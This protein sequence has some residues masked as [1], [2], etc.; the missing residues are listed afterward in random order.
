MRVKVLLLAVFAFVA[1]NVNGQELKFGAKAGLNVSNFTGSDANTKSKMGFHFGAFAQYGFSEALYLQPELL[2]S[3]EG[4]KDKDND[5]K[6][7]SV[8]YLNVPVM[9]GYKIGSISIEAGPQIGFLLGAKY[10]GESEIM[11]M[12]V[13]DQFKSTNFSLNLGAGYAISE[14]IGVGV[15]YCIGLA[16]VSDNSGTDFKTSNFQVS[17]GYKF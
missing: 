4:G 7:L 13:K 9:V 14:N 6:V 10:D 1:M 5:N 12:K 15:R 16:N 2:L 8:T 17:L 11:G 3:F